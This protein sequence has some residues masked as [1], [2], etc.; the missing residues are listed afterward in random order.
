MSTG[1]VSS[2]NSVSSSTKPQSSASC[3]VSQPPTFMRS[4]KAFGSFLQRVAYI[5]AT[6]ASIFSKSVLALPRLSMSWLMPVA[7][8]LPYSKNGS[9]HWCTR[10]MADLSM[11]MCLAPIEAMVAALAFMPTK[12]AWT[13]PCRLKAEEILNAVLSCPPG[14]SIS[15]ATSLSGFLPRI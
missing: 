3:A 8:R 12:C 11:V 2:S 9:A 6:F 7:L 15:T 5:V 13:L 10:Y 14:L 1:A 4:S